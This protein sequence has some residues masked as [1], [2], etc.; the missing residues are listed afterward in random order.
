MIKKLFK[1]IW[2]NSEPQDLHVHVHVHLTQDGVPASPQV[3]TVV[4]SQPEKVKRVSR[5]EA[6]ANEIA[7]VILAGGMPKAVD[8][9]GDAAIQ[10]GETEGVDEQLDALRR[11]KQR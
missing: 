11:L 10:K 9:S 5:D 3:T 6:T 1:W 4:S 8:K 2:G 7:Q